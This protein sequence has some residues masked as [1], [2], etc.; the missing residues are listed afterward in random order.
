MGQ[1]D[2]EPETVYL[3]RPF[4]Y[5]ILDAKYR[6][7]LFIGTMMDPTA[8]PDAEKTFSQALQIVS[9]FDKP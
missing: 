3:A 1:P 6:V 4:V 9:A 7:P 5:M 2:G 8:A